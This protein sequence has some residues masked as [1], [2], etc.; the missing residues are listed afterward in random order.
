MNQ[1]FSALT[2]RRAIIDRREVADRLTGLIEKADTSETSALRAIIV[3][4]LADAL[5]AGK[6]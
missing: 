3:S 6:Q 1:N 2:N 5:A 4:V